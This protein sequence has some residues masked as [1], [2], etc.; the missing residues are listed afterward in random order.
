MTNLRSPASRHAVAAAI[1]ALCAMPPLTARAAG[2]LNADCS[3]PGPDEIT[4]LACNIYYEAR[5]QSEAGQLAVAMVTLN[6]LRAPDYP[7][8]I[9]AVVWET[10]R[11]A[12]TGSLVAQFSWTQER[13]AGPIEEPAWRKALDLAR[14]AVGS[15]E[16]PGSEPDPSLGALFFHASYVSPPWSS[17]GSLD[18]TTRIGDHL[19]YKDPNV[20]SDARPLHVPMVRQRASVVPP[21]GSAALPPD[22]L[23]WV[24]P[25]AKL[26][27]ISAGTAPNTVSISSFERGM[28]RTIVVGRESPVRKPFGSATSAPFF[29]ISFP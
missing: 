15:L 6:R 23:P 20:T 5:N 28:V 9:C 2:L 29:P 3:G 11:V 16:R 25:G 10:R 7:K 18:L 12:R 13:H 24:R 26:I 14:R 17:D 27:R 1:M 21:A 22:A 19:F 4:C 8:S